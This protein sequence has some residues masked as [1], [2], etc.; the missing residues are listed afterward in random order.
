MDAQKKLIK[1]LSFDF[2]NLDQ[3]NNDNINLLKNTCEKYNLAVIKNFIPKDQI[4]NSMNIIK[5]KFKKSN[6]SIRMKNEYHKVQT[7]YQR[8]CS[9]YGSNPSTGE[10]R[11]CR[12]FRILYNPTFEENIYDL[13]DISRKMIIFRNRLYDIRDNFCLDEPEDNLFSCSRIH[14]FPEGGGFLQL[15]KDKDGVITSSE[16][17]KTYF[18]PLLIMNKKGE[19]FNSGGGIIKIEDEI[20]FYED[21]LDVGDLVIYNGRSLHGVYNIDEDKQL[22]LDTFNGR[23]SLLVSLFKT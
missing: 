4:Q 19:D 1:N 13:H 18:N 8:F 10:Y 9:G 22:N 21:Y 7:N 2:S 11:N 12:L 5:D 14:Q 3:L 6:D 23:S 17:L 16:N 15:H 20:I